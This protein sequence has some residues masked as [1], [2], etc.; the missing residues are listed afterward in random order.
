MVETPAS[1]FSETELTAAEAL[2][3][4]AR[5]CRHFAHQ[6]A[7]EVG[8]SL[9]ELAIELERAADRLDSKIAASA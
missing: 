2:R 7:S 4:R 8:T 3:H 1:I 5:R 6:Y 9:V